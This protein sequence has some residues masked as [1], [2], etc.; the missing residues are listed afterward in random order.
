MSS[1]STRELTLL[2]EQAALQAGAGRRSARTLAHATVQ[3]ELGG[4]PAVGVGHLF[5]YLDG[6]RAGRISAQAVP[7]VRRAVP[8]A[9]DVDAGGGLAQDAFQ[10]VREELL[11]AVRAQG[12]VGLWIRRSFTCGELGYYPRAVAEEGLVAFAA[13]NSPALMSVGGS[14]SRLL[15]T[16]PLAYGF[17]AEEGAVVIDQAS[18]ATAF[19]NIRRAAEAGQEIPKGWALDSQGTPTTDPTEALGGTLLPFGSHRGGNVALLVEMLATLS[20]ANFSMDAAPFD[21]GDESP[22]IGVFLLCIDPTL[23]GDAAG[24]LTVHLEALRDQH[25][26]RLPALER[27]ELPNALEIDDDLLR[28]LSSVVS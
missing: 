10:A 4:N 18:S 7:A 11:A 1:I 22:G 19:V 16:N 13:A 17:P 9:F 21:H 14:A 3:A 5:D 28:R 2:C 26:V 12:I 6:Y 24:R 20:G 25:G 27:R 23:F 8:G 15:G